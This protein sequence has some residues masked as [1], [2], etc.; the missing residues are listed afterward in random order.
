M[1][2]IMVLMEDRVDAVTI[3]VPFD[4]VREL[5]RERLA[6]PLPLFRGAALDAVV[7][8][9]MDSAALVTLLQAPDSV[10]NFATWVRRRCA[11]SGDTIEISATR[12][13]RRVQL[14]VDG[15]IDVS[16][17]TDFLLAA[18]ADHQTQP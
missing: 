11:T 4:A 3:A 10:R 9:G 15:N 2:S 7:T 13:D 12:G 8:I 6:F 5:E 17:V 1:H 18:F 14:K 16:V